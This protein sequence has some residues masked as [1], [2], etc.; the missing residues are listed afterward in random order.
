MRGL[1][2]A[3]PQCAICTHPEGLRTVAA[4]E[5]GD[6]APAAYPNPEHE[7][8]QWFHGTNYDPKLGDLKTADERGEDHSGWRHWNT[9]LGTHFT[10]IHSTAKSF[11][12]REFDPIH[13]RIA[14]ASL[15]MESPLHYESENHMTDEAF[16]WARKNGFKDYDHHTDG[17]T[18][19]RSVKEY[20]ESPEDHKWLNKDL[21]S[22]SG[23]AEGW[24][25]GHPRIGE[26]AKGFKEHLQGQ[27]FDGITYGNEHEKPIGHTS[28]I[29]FKETP[30]RVHQWEKIKAPM[31]R[32]VAMGMEGPDYD[33]LTFRHS[34]IGDDGDEEGHDPIGTKIITAHHPEHGQV[35]K[36]TY[37]DME[38]AEW[39]GHPP[40]A[41]HI[42]MLRVHQNHRRRGVGTQLMKHLEDM[43]PD[44]PIDH[45]TRTRMG[46]AWGRTMYGRESKP[47]T[48]NEFRM[49]KPETNTYEPTHY[50][51]DWTLNGKPWNV[52]TKKFLRPQKKMSSLT[53]E[54]ELNE[55]HSQSDLIAHAEGTQALY[56][57]A[58]EQMYG[59]GLCGA[60]A[61]Q[62]EKERSTQFS[63]IGIHG[64]D[65]DEKPSQRWVSAG[66][67]SCGTCTR[68]QNEFLNR[69]PGGPNE[70]LD[71]PRRSPE[72]RPHSFN[73]D[74]QVPFDPSKFHGLP[75]ST[76]KES[77]F[78]PDERVF[79]HT[80]GLDHR[81]FDA[82][83]HLKPDVR[84]YIMS[85]VQRILFASHDWSRWAIVYFA[86]SE[87]SE[88]TS[89]TLEGN[90]DFDVLIGVDYPGFR[91]A[92]PQ[93]AHMSSQAITDL[94]N[95]GFRQFNG[96]VMLTIDGKK[97]GPFDRTT[98]VNPDSY[99]IRKIK[100]YAAYNVSSDEW[101]VKPP[102][103]PHWSLS[104]LPRAVQ[105]VLRAASNYA[106]HVLTL[107]EPERTQQGAALFDSWHSD[108][109]RAFSDKGEGW[110]DI[111][112]LR[113]KWLD[114][115][116]VWAEIV[117][118]KHRA[119]EGLDAAPADWSNMPKFAY[120]DF[121]GKV[122]EQLPL[123]PDL[124]HGM[125][126]WGMYKG[127]PQLPL[128]R[129]VA[130]PDVHEHHLEHLGKS[131]EHDQ[132]IAH[133]LMDRIDTQ[134]SDRGHRTQLG[135]H[136]SHDPE[137]T[138]DLANTAHADW[139]NGGEHGHPVMLEAD[140]PGHEHVIDFSDPMKEQGGGRPDK[141]SKDWHLT[142]D[143]IGSHNMLK[144]MLPEVPIRPGAPMHL[145]A[146][147]VQKPNGDFHRIPVGLR[148]KAS[149][150]TDAV[151]Q[152]GKQEHPNVDHY[153]SGGM[154]H[155]EGDESR[156]VVGFMPVEELKR[157]R[158]HAG[159]WNGA[160]SD[161]AVAKIREDLRA[162]KGIHTPLMVE[163]NP[164]IGWGYLGEGNHRLRALDEEGFKTAPVRVVRSY[165]SVESR[166]AKGIGAPM[167][168]NTVFNPADPSYVPSDIHPHHFI[169]TST[170]MAE[171]R[172]WGAGLDTMFP[173]DEDGP[174]STSPAPW[175][176]A[177]QRKDRK[178]YDEE[179]VGRSITHPHEFPIEEVDPRD[180]RATQPKV[181]R[182]GVQHYMNN[183][184]GKTYGED[185]GGDH[186]LGNDIPR[187]YHREDGQKLILAGHHRAA[188]A[189]AK[190]EK[191][192]AMV[193]HGGWGSARNAA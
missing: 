181:M 172:H 175:P 33:G 187:I 134:H 24:L 138:M 40:R 48:G 101:T 145:R 92:N 52:R 139:H 69:L 146:I 120:G 98:Y 160:H 185:N 5:F 19:E 15:H 135:I 10:S 78:T 144:F 156:S 116:G 54:G 79:T 53:V 152:I 154:G 83:G 153:Q 188:A 3:D 124:G 22:R 32:R 170:V 128:Y 133:H 140:H 4:H 122:P 137:A 103:L 167:H 143:T 191:L 114:Q 49:Y 31:D 38:H 82:D 148:T 105:Q 112:N 35:G 18:G 173:S 127:S 71:G 147:H 85:S 28:A 9:H 109:S 102:H 88:W 93:Y 107:P 115:E 68:H 130:L 104:E 87:A 97:Y 11:A 136:W 81:L 72:S 182:A 42:N 106:H 161:E 60:H 65:E 132:A 76:S 178:S 61:L 177:G 164:T 162:G 27:G 166:K 62:R 141:P 45:G 111:A 17:K 171:N 180:L 44:I 117:D 23:D 123:H 51:A 95:Q 58:G 7:H 16:R 30:V 119:N 67:G 75:P 159:N 169:K 64:F 113:E 77:R 158:E 149:A 13:A 37:I 108:R 186:R 150:A 70:R 121:T 14:H 29:A 26:L 59:P 157:Y 189:L 80:C 165:G 100:P 73:P 74:R 94:F 39:T 43:H 12:T 176:A 36:L 20:D 55:P 142:N 96:P 1:H 25:Q 47:K 174:R 50:D 84:K 126:E 184:S 193:I 168:T 99:D 34:E 125:D 129:G 155:M 8:G 57:P 46:E 118:C 41:L 183:P 91:R 90:N 192:R 63:D 66:K 21:L 2:S 190:G 86:G 110:W 179:L 56:K 163:H 151:T 131:P 89:D 6:H